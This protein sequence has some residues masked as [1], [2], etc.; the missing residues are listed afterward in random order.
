MKKHTLKIQL[1]VLSLLWSAVCA[2]SQTSSKTSMIELLQNCDTSIVSPFTRN[3]SGEM[4][5]HVEYNV[6]S[7][8]F[9]ECTMEFE[10]PQ[11]PVSYDTYVYD[12][13]IVE[14]ECVY[15]ALNQLVRCRKFVKTDKECSV[16]TCNIRKVCYEN[17]KSSDHA[18]PA[19][20]GYKGKGHFEYSYTLK[21]KWGYV[22]C[23]KSGRKVNAFDRPFISDAPY[24]KKKDDWFIEFVSTGESSLCRVLLKNGF[25]DR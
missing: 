2:Y 9:N 25:Y 12:N 8:L 6:G 13:Q 14:Y 21:M 16:Y 15:N 24:C 19:V 5:R 3:E 1:A 18:M 23:W 7:S 10:F 17:P 20:N 4:Y 11:S 22:Y